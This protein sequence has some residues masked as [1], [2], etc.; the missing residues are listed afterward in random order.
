MRQKILIGS[1][2]LTLW[3]TGALQAFLL[4]SMKTIPEMYRPPL[5]LPDGYLVVWLIS[6][7]N[8]NC[9]MA[10]NIHER[11]KKQ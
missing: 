9:R 3:G 10:G 7:I 8:G 11:S 6:C 5:S 2:M 4:E 1:V